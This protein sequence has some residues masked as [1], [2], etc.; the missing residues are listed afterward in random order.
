[1]FFQKRKKKGMSLVEL[2]ISV[3]VLSIGILGLMLFFT[4]AMLSTELAREITVAT[5]HA[6]YTL[7]EMKTRSTLAN[8]TSTNWVSWYTGQS[9]NTLN[10]EAL[11]VTITNT[12]ADPLD[13]TAT[14]TW[15]KRG[16]TNTVSLTTKIHK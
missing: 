15:N 16:R 14:I 8:I 6:E 2:L 9:L 11:T 3:F 13:I 1:M 4:N 7:E 12:S 5:S 10:S